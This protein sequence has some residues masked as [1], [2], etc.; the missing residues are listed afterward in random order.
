[1]MDVEQ[2]HVIL[3]QSF[4][5]DANLRNPAEATIRNLKHVMGSTVLLLQ[6]V[7]EKQVSLFLAFGDWIETKRINR[8]TEILSNNK[9][10][11]ETSHVSHTHQFFCIETIA[12]SSDLCTM[13]F[14][15]FWNVRFN[16]KYGKLPPSN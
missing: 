10:N 1:M 14:C 3:Q 13:T 9:Q 4:S 7:A 15:L 12:F 8:S 2:L 16:S 5:A 6:V 11:C